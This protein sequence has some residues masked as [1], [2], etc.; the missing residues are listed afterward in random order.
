M[1]TTLDSTT[2]EAP[3]ARVLS[4]HW[5]EPESWTAQLRSHGGYDGVRAAFAMS[6]DEVIELVKASGLQGCG[7]A[8]FPVG[9]EM[10]FI[11]QS[12]DPD[13]PPHYLVVNA[14]ESGT[15]HRK[16]HAADAV[17]AA[18]ADRGIIIACYAVGPPMRSST[19]AVRL[20][21]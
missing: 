12:D 11:P 9:M 4:A 1:T 18:C 21:P 13:A 14:D 2:A 3:D 20:L 19:C 7:G 15:R 17:V 10:G 6:P 8:G 5:D 16:G